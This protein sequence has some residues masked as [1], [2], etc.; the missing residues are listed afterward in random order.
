V[1]WGHENVLMHG[2]KRINAGMERCR[3][4]EMEGIQHVSKKRL[5]HHCMLVREIQSVWYPSLE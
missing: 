1:S 3:D 4:A 2:R 5:R